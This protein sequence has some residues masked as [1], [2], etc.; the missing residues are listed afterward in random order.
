MTIALEAALVGLVAGYIIFRVD[1]YVKRNRGMALLIEVAAFLACLLS[2]LVQ[3][4]L[5]IGFGRASLVLVAIP[6]LIA[7][8][9]LPTFIWWRLPSL[10]RKPTKP[11][12]ND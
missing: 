10:Q 2:R 4:G 11:Q 3:I 9:L 12:E 8:V 7:G 5:A 1:G 6:F